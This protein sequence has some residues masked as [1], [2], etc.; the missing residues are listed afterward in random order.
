VTYTTG[1]R[2]GL[3]PNRNHALTLIVEDLV[4]FLDDDCLLGPDFLATAV[5][6]MEA[7]EATWG[8][9]RVVVSG[10]EANNGRLVTAR[11]QDFLGFQSR[12][13]SKGAPMSSIVINATLFPRAAFD[14]HR[15]DAQIRYGYE[16]VDLASR[17]A[18]DGYRIVESTDAVNIHQPSSLGRQ[19]YDGVV[20]ASRL[21]VTVKRY[22]R[23]ERRYGRAAAFAVVGPLHAMAAGARR[24]GV[25]GLRA[26]IR[27]TR[28]AVTY[29]VRHANE[30]EA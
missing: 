13:Y 9:E 4:L 6:H 11:A 8:Q 16:E 7:N 17:L 14:R 23:T 27:A 5:A 24:D 22:A 20:T 12:P 25:D 2:R 15:F 1:P 19:D 28:L 18:Q 29:V 3:S 10:A 21:Y 30:A 26:A